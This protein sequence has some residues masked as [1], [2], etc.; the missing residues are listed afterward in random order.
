MVLIQQFI[1]HF[2]VLNQKKIHMLSVELE[3]SLNIRA[4]CRMDCF[5]LGWKFGAN[6]A[7]FSGKISPQNS[8]QNFHDCLGSK[9]EL[10]LIITSR[11][12]N[13]P[14]NR[15]NLIIL[16]VKALMYYWISWHIFL[17]FWVVHFSEFL[18]DFFT[19]FSGDLDLLNKLYLISGD[20]DLLNKKYLIPYDPDLLNTKS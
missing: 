14:K 11:V 4:R 16:F 3:Q 2:T 12:H 1:L 6:L 7:E 20:L 18:C 8:G 13:F 5:N 17:N 19:E 10:R 15:V 9:F